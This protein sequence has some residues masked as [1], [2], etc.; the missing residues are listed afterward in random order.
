[1]H[2]LRVATVYDADVEDLPAELRSALT[3]QDVMAIR[4]G[5]KFFAG[6]AGRAEAK[7]LKRLLQEC[8]DS[9]FELQFCAVDDAPYRPYYRFYWGGEPAVSLP[10]RGRLRAD[11]PPFLRQVYGVIGAFRENAFDMAGGLVPADK[12]A[13]VSEMDM[14]VEPGGPIDPGKAVPFLETFSGSQL[15][16]LPDGTGAWLEEAGQFRQVKNLERETARYFEA[17][18]RCTRI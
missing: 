9:G 13:P 16:F 4:T 10:R 12:L 6:L 2:I 18:L 5:A 7:W 1:M 3:K 11:L 17:L 8:A 14:W 15:C